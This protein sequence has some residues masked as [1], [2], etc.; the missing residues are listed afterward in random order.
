MRLLTTKPHG[1]ARADDDGRSRGI[2]RSARDS[3][4]RLP[5]RTAEHIGPPSTIP[6]YAILSHTWDEPSEVT[7]KE[8]DLFTHSTGPWPQ[9]ITALLP[10]SVGLV[11]L[12][13]RWTFHASAN[14]ELLEEL[15][16][17][18]IA[19]SISCVIHYK[20]TLYPSTNTNDVKSLQQKKPGYD[21]IRQTI[22]LAHL[23]GLKHAWVDTCCINKDSS[24]EL[25]ESINSMYAWYAAAKVCFV[26]LS[27]LDPA[28]A[29]ENLEQALPRCRWFKRGWT[30]QELIAPRHVIFYDRDWNERGTKDS[31]SSLLSKIT[32]IPEELLRG[33]K[34]L[35]H[36]AVGRRMSW[37][38]M[39]KT[40][41]R[42]DEAYCLLGIFN[43]NMPLLYGEGEA[44]FFRL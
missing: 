8:L 24:A 40:T 6:S 2:F 34:R 31:L 4:E 14:P 43:V 25:S 39:R 23:N 12:G 22:R 42:E 5:I 1:F 41:R 17:I 27:D 36:Y 28:A 20:I 15:A 29:D 37:A 26:Y 30:L 9:V 13:Y 21:K 38:S 32:T 10:L 16:P 19:I 3:K 18:L 33:D 44:A 7:F 35:D 11:Y